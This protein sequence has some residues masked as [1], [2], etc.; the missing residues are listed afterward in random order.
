MRV[1]AFGANN[2][3][4]C[5]MNYA[6]ACDAIEEAVFFDP[7]IEGSER[8]LS[9]GVEVFS[10]PSISE[11]VDIIQSAKESLA[12]SFYRIQESRVISAIKKA[13]Q[14]GVKI[15]L[16]MNDYRLSDSPFHVSDRIPSTVKKLMGNKIAEMAFA[17]EKN[18]TVRFPDKHRYALSHQKYMVIDNNRVVVSTLNLNESGFVAKNLLAVIKNN[19]E[20]THYFSKWFAKDFMRENVAIARPQSVLVAPGNYY[21]QTGKIIRQAGKTLDM[22]YPALSD[23]DLCSCIMD[24]MR[25][26]TSVR[27]ITSSNVF[28]KTVVNDD[29]IACLRMLYGSG[30]VEIRL[31][32]KPAYAHA[33]VLLADVNSTSGI[34]AIGSAAFM[35]Q[36][37]FQSQEAGVLISAPE[38]LNEIAKFYD[39][40]WRLATPMDQAAYEKELSILRDGNQSFAIHNANRS[41]SNR[42]P[43]AAM[44]NQGA[45]SLSYEIK[46]G[47]LLGIASGFTRTLMSGCAATRSYSLLVNPVFF[48]L[49]ALTR[50]VSFRAAA[51]LFVLGSCQ[52]KLALPAHLQL[53][54]G[55]VMVVAISHY[56]KQSCGITLIELLPLIVSA[57]SAEAGRRVGNRAGQAFLSLSKNAMVFFC[58]KNVPSELGRVP[59]VAKRLVASP[60]SSMARR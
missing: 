6:H 42:S 4:V 41:G 50:G 47:L 56:Q 32:N 5:P 1:H 27:V 21:V 20:V 30:H 35:G 34:A 38:S 18:I 19:P 7:V 48:A 46:Q 44:E 39:D 9:S 31:L 17:N 29:M 12:I 24:S 23:R 59:K 16:M 10:M 33:K 45:S 57:L 37:Y 51:G 43:G 15:Q 36:S 3:L 55:A 14:R 22:M 49:N 13:A 53:I 25:E 60:V 40:S 8:A 11:V 28:G 58:N 54:I 52:S 26:T 2:R